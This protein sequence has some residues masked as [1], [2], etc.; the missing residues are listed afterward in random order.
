MK[1]LLRICIFA[2]AFVMLFGFSAV[3]ASAESLADFSD[4][5]ESYEVTGAPMEKDSAIKATWENN[6]LR[7]GDPVGMDSHIYDVGKIAYENGTSGNKVLALNNTGAGNTFFYIGP[8]GDYR[9]KNFTVQFRVKFLVDNV[10][11]RTWIG[12]SFRKKAQL[13]YT[14]TNNLMFVIQRYVNSNQIGGNA[15]AVFD[16]GNTNDLALLGDL[17][18]EKLSLDKEVYTVPNGKANEDLPWVTYK[19]VANENNYKMYINDTLVT[20]CTFNVNKYDYYGYLSLNCCIAN[21]LVDD[22]AVT[23]QDEELPPVIAP[24]TAPVLSVN[25]EEKELNWDYVEG[26]STYRVT[27][28]GEDTT[29][30][31]NYYDLSKLPV[32]THTITV[33]AISDDTFLALDSN[34]SESITYTV[35]GKADNTEKPTKKGCG[36]VTG[37]ELP[38]ILSVLGLGAVFSKRR[39]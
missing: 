29:A 14:G 23:V 13:H 28:D 33:T 26:A 21:V 20:D 31:Y 6:V 25:A 32:G 19:L 24:L 35:E 30:F 34:P 2:L 38:L 5:F 27:V 15:F 18:G 3:T 7:D 4:D 9:V 17:Y 36:G 12:I 39:R 22:F 16:G 1:K 11:E 10:P 8:K 37:V